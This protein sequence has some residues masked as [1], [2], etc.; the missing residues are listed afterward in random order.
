MVHKEI[1]E[2]LLPEQH[3][4]KSRERR[5]FY[6]V[7][8]QVYAKPN[9]NCYIRVCMALAPLLVHFGLLMLIFTFLLSR[10]SVQQS[11]SIFFYGT[12]ALCNVFNLCG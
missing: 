7:P 5:G 4:L 11:T 8:L 10:S 12:H 1:E 9:L 6:F 2:A 3:I